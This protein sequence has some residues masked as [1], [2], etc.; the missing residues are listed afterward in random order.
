MPHLAQFAR[1]SE[2]RHGRALAQNP[3]LPG[4]CSAALRVFACCM[5]VC[6]PRTRGCRLESGCLVDCMH[7][8]CPTL[9]LELPVHP[10]RGD[11]TDRSRALA[12][13]VWGSLEMKNRV[14]AVSP[15]SSHG[16][17]HTSISLRGTPL[18]GPKSCN[19]GLAKESRQGVLGCR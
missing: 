3:P 15:A 5:F 6:A 19:R 10:R 14:P 13:Q 4:T 11:R 2:A 17:W 18:D 12:Q 9:R 1:A 8:L 7:A 16:G